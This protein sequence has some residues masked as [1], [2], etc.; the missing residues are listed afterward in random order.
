MLAWCVAVRG[1]PSALG[2]LTKRLNAALAS[3]DADELTRLAASASAIL[4]RGRAPDVPAQNDPIAEGD[5]WTFDNG[6]AS[7]RILANGVL[8][9]CARSD[10]RSIV[11]PANVLVVEAGWRGHKQA[12]AVA[13]TVAGGGADL[14]LSAG[15]ARLAMRVELQAGEPFVRV[16]VAAAGSGDAWVENR[17]AAS[18]VTLCGP[19]RERCALIASDTAALAILALDAARWRQ[20]ELPKG[21]VAVDMQ[22]GDVAGEGASA[23]WA[24]A[25]LAADASAGEAEAMWQRFVYGPRVRLFQS[26]EYGVLVEGCGPADDGDGVIVTLRECDGRARDMR[27]RCGGRM[28]EAEGATIDREYLVA[29]IGANETREL[30]VRF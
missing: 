27:V 25:P 10:A 30:R 24:F 6:V 15:G 7:A 22:L 4:P 20:R 29:P 13:G 11:A 18:R 12:K 26:T 9:E 21:G 19:Q 1:A 14:Q 28:R 5:G 8:T 17:F 16:D 2:V 3:R 23:S